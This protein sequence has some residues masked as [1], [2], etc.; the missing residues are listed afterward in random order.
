MPVHSLANNI[1]IEVER[2][3]IIPD[4]IEDKI[5]NLGGHQV[6]DEKFEDE[7]F[8]TASYKL[9]RSDCSLRLRKTKKSTWLLKYPPTRTCK[10]GN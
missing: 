5:A 9:T 8:D 7:Y 4:L 6:V 1:R 10:V 3:F 2:K